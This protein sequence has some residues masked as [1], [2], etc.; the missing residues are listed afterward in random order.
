MQAKQITVSIK[1]PLSDELSDSHG[2]QIA[3]QNIR[4]R[5]QALYGTR[6]KMHVDVNN[7]TYHVTLSWPYWNKLDEDTDH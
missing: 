3:Q 7:Q 6:G 5:L 4:D 2:N 1:N